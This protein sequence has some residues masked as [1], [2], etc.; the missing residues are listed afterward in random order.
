MIDEDLLGVEDLQKVAVHGVQ[1]RSWVKKTLRK[2]QTWERMEA[3]PKGL[4]QG[5]PAP[6]RLEMTIMQ[7][8]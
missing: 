5:L 1:F 3:N 4:P 7:K 6:I 8:H 2:A